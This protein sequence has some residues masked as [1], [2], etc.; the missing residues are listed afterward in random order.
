MKKNLL[1]LILSI[2]FISNAFTQNDSPIV[3]SIEAV[4]ISPSIISITWSLPQK[5]NT[6]HINS[7]KLYKNTRPIT[8]YSDLKN[9]SPIATIPFGRLSYND[10]VND[11]CEYFYA[12]VSMIS[13]GSYES[14]DLYF[15]EEFDLPKEKQEEQELKL[16]IPGVNATV[17]GA[18]I[19]KKLTQN[20]EIPIQQNELKNKKLNTE[21]REK[22]LPYID[23]FGDEIPHEA[24]I[25]LASEKN[26]KKLINKNRT[27]KI[28]ILE[29]YIF[30]E[31]LISPSGGDDY[32]LFEILKSSFIKRKYKNAII[33]L[34]KFLAQ[35]REK[36]TS[37]RANFYLG[38]AYYFT[39]KLELAIIQFL[40][41]ETSY[42]ELS[43]KWIENT[44]DLY[45]IPKA[46]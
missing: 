20:L 38:Q 3:N 34:N 41:L 29:P 39:G 18:K 12:I 23:I 19:K 35:N 13:E 21:L 11:S 46:E 1:K 26:A 25:S 16:I 22:P 15:D 8:S 32:L 6:K 44:L 9:L 31:D 5:T 42:P 28:T 14:Q 2:I 7:L 37:D 40:N 43:N 17:L 33:E 27:K 10:K 4:G 36:S 30:E 45:Q 24:S